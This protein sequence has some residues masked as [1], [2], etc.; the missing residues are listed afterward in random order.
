M[1]KLQLR[2]EVDWM[3][4]SIMSCMSNF[5][6]CWVLVGCIICG[7]L[8]SLPAAA[9]NENLTCTGAEMKSYADLVFCLPPGVEAAAASAVEEGNYTAGRVVRAA[10]L[11][12]GSRVSLHLLYPCQA[13]AAQL[14]P[15]AMKSLLEAYD[16]A[17]KQASYFDSLL[18]INGRPAIGGQVAD[19]IFAAYQP[20]NQTVALI[21]MDMNM[22]QD[23]MVSFL[24]GLRIS[25]KEGSSPLSAGY[26]QGTTAVS[27]VG[28][29]TAPSGAKATSQLSPA[30]ARAA[31]FQAAKEKMA[32]DM[33]AARKKLESARGSMMGF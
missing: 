12:N 27:A 8:T 24:S 10:L 22:S 3:T 6:V 18:N 20:T 13:P 16:P 14:E 29:E 19:Q 33:E 9:Q 7:I 17:M 5:R 1:E 2:Y 21:L 31:Q 32:A 4:I 28:K 23:L 30:E 15:A 26:C 25:P 11:I